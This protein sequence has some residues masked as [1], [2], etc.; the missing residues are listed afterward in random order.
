MKRLFFLSLC[1]LVA[2][3]ASTV[4][5]GEASV[6]SLHVGA[7]CTQASSPALPRALLPDTESFLLSAGPAQPC[8]RVWLYRPSSDELSR[9]PR[10]ADEAGTA[11]T[12]AHNDAPPLL[13]LL[14]GNATFAL[15]VSAA[16][17]QA[18]LIG[19]VVIAAIAPAN[20]TLFDERQRFRDYTSI[21]GDTWGVPHDTSGHDL[22][23]GGA[24][25]FESFIEGPLLDAVAARVPVSPTHRTLFG[26][27]LGGFLVLHDLLTR[28]RVFSQ[29]FAASPSI[30][31]ND[32]ELLKRSRGLREQLRAG[33]VPD[34]QLTAV[35]LL[36]S[37]GGDEQRIAP[38]ATAVRI[39]RVQHAAMLDNLRAFNAV[40]KEMPACG[41]DT[42]L[43][44]YPGQN[45]VS[46]LPAA[47][48]D[49]VTF[50]AGRQR[51]ATE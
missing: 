38:D 19:P 9:S 6:P 22:P 44:M 3:S 49:A 8:Y 12:A 50:A 35:K 7:S 1:M 20:D 10:R 2:L 24:T 27:S 30:W 32:R 36:L 5:A 29:Y 43:T 28:P 15:A 48:S 26:H 14:D 37:A 4:R 41:I 11:T 17:L 34:E 46:Y 47:I 40:L 23:T 13:V 16:R 42:H 39:E 45:H 31:W 21:A 51:A 18:R 33:L 25:D